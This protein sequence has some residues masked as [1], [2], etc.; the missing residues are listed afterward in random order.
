MSV[1]VPR[2]IEHNHDQVF[3]VAVEASGDGPEVLGHGRIEADGVLRAHADDELFHVEVGRVQKAA[4]VRR[5]EH[6]QGIRRARGTEIGPLERIDGDVDP[7]QSQP[8]R[9]PLPPC[10]PFHR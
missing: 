6:R 9:L 7:G 4:A 10:R 8:R 2:A 5:R 3:D 1:L